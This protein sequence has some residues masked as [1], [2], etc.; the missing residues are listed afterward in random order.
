MTGPLEIDMNM[1]PGTDGIYFTLPL[2]TRLALPKKQLQLTGILLTT[3][4]DVTRDDLLA[5]MLAQAGSPPEGHCDRLANVI[6]AL[7]G[8]H[9]QHPSTVILHMFR[10]IYKPEGTHEKW[11]IEV[12]FGG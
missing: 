1:T 6:E 4:Q 3:D 7:T 11:D 2:K 12:T 10:W 9:L 5:E 8:Q